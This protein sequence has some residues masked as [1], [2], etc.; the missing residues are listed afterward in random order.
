MNVSVEVHAMPRIT[1]T[2]SEAGFDGAEKGF[3]YKV[4]RFLPRFIPSFMRYI[5]QVVGL[6]A[7]LHDQVRQRKE[8]YPGVAFRRLEALVESLDS[9]PGAD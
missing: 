9:A 3:A 4:G 2:P 6:H 8:A 1:N 7:C 5:Q